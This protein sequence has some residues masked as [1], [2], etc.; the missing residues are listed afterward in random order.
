MSRVGKAFQNVGFVTLFG[1]NNGSFSCLTF[2]PPLFARVL[3]WLNQWF[4]ARKF[5]VVTASLQSYCCAELK[6]LGSTHNGLHVAPQ[7]TQRKCEVIFTDVEK[8]SKLL[9]LNWNPRV[10]CEVSTSVGSDDIFTSFKS[11]ICLNFHNWPR[12]MA[13]IFSSSLV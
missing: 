8:I 9:Q 5:A 2:L 12:G 10:L 13:S 1:Y 3:N 7:E 6:G 11:L 4:P